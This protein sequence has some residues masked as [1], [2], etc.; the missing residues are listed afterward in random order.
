MRIPAV[1]PK[2]TE[3]PGGTRWLGPKLGE[4]T[5][6]VLSA[7]GYSEAQQAELRGKQVI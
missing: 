6:E 1:T 2:L 4:H 7:L 5:A 3:S